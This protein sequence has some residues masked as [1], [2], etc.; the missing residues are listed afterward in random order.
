[1]S[2]NTKRY[3]SVA[4]E[5]PEFIRD[6]SEIVALILEEQLGL[7]EL[8]A[9]DVGRQVAER[10]AREYAGE[11]LYIPKSQHVIAE[12]DREI[13]HAYDGQNRDAICRKFEL[14]IPRFYAI[15]QKGTRNGWITQ[16]EQGQF[17]LSSR[18]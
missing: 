7:D 10:I 2:T 12:R 15:I 16:P 4:D 11:I 8:E 17:D 3:R 9:S 13:C 5:L 6:T 14:S 18:P 1:M